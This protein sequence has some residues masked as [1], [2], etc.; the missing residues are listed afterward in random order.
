LAFRVCEFRSVDD[1][2]WIE[3]DQVTGM[4]GTQEYLKTNV[5]IPLWKLT[6]E[7]RRDRSDR[8]R[9]DPLDGLRCRDEGHHGSEDH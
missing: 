6:T 4:I 2:G 8:G 3:A 1:S 5:L 9:R 7:W